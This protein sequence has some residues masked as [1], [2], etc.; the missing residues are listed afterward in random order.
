MNAGHSCCS[1][2]HEEE[3]CTTG[4][5]KCQQ[6]RQTS[7]DKLTGDDTKDGHTVIGTGSTKTL[8]QSGDDKDQLTATEPARSITSCGK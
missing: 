3:D 2:E 4:C 1:A 6:E 5:S 7:T 8:P